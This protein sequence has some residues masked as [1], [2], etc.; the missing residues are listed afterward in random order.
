MKRCRTLA[1]ALDLTPGEIVSFVGGGG[2][3]GALIRLIEELRLGGWR[4][5]AST[6]TKVGRS[7]EAA[8]PVLELEEGDGALRRAV[9]TEGAVFVAGGAEAD[10]KLRGVDPAAVDRRMVG[11]ADAVLVEADGSRQMPIKAPGDHEPV[12]PS[13]TT[14]VV[15]MVGLDAMSRPIDGSH[16]HRPELL[17]ALVGGGVVT[18][19]AIV[20]LITSQQGGLKAV[21]PGA[22]VRPILNKVAPDSR[23]AAT[24]IAWSLLN[25]G[26]SHLDRV[27]V[28]DVSTADFSYL[29]RSQG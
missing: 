6:T 14:L 4:V 1:H 8:V 16:A 23:Q 29:D 24:R 2:K 13:S 28:A 21:P 3:T 12:V 27:V 22:R 7:I 10:G 11:M 26:P 25:K 20:R 9:D 17:S 15:P 18:E 19:D 5:L